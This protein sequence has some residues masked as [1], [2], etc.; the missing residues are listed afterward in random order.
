[1]M[2]KHRLVTITGG[3]KVYSCGRGIK[4]CPRKMTACRD[5]EP[6]ER[7]VCRPRVRVRIWRKVAGRLT[8]T[9]QWRV[10]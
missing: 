10:K 5:F 1:M 9:L 7:R 8:I 2:C 6:V 3:K 4:S